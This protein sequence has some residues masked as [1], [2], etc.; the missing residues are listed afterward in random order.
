[1]DGPDGRVLSEGVTAP[2]PGWYPDP[3]GRGG[4]FRW[5]DGDDWTDRTRSRLPGRANRLVILVLGFSLVVS[6][7][8]VGLFGWRSYHDP[9]TAGQG[10]NTGAPAASPRTTSPARGSAPQQPDGHMDETTRVAMLADGRM[11]LPGRPY[12]MVG[13]PVMVPGVFDAM[14][15]ANAPVRPRSDGSETWAAT[16]G[17]AHIPAGAWSEDD[18]PGFAHKA[19]TRFSE[20]FFGYHPKSVRNLSYSAAVVSGR[21]CAKITATVYYQAK[22]MSSR[23]ARLVIIGCPAANNSVI[24]AISSV[25]DDAPAPLPELA[26]ASLATFALS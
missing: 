26:R 18:L 25:P 17:L 1:M 6:G 16:V 5:W 19:L 9:R 13:A 7:G 2:R 8:V 10:V 22:Q 15:V 14:F 20:H 4:T 21:T 12:A 11:T 23:Y 3:T 24:A